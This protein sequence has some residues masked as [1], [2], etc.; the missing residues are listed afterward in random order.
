MEFKPEGILGLG[1]FG[2]VSMGVWRKRDVAIKRPHKDKESIQQYKNERAILS[3]LNHPNIVRYLG[4]LHQS[5]SYG[6]ILELMP[7]GELFKMIRCGEIPRDIQY[8]I[9]LDIAHGLKYLCAERI[10]HR[11]LKSENI[12]LGNHNGRIVAK[13]ADFGFAASLDSGGFG[14]LCG[15]L[16]FIAPELFM[17]YSP[18]P[19]SFNSDTYAFSIIL[20][21]MV[22]RR[23]M[24]ARTASIKEKVIQGER[25]TFKPGSI[26]GDYQQLIIDCWAGNPT[27]RPNISKIIQRLSEIQS[28]LSIS[29]NSSNQSNSS[30]HSEMGE[31][32]DLLV[33]A[34]YTDVFL[35][36]KQLDFY[37]R[38]LFAEHRHVPGE[39]TKKLAENLRAVMVKLVQGDLS[40]EAASEEITM[41]IR[42]GKVTMG[43]HR[44][45]RDII[46]H[47]A[48]CC[49]LLGLP[50]I[51]INKCYSGQLFFNKTVRQQK[52][53]AVTEAVNTAGLLTGPT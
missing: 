24:F 9:A 23:N 16:E 3:H 34:E 8:S 29:L 18:Y 15:T 37:S 4:Q 35:S 1:T 31:C 40:K 45:W 26:S 2:T 33:P 10:V 28:S 46:A 5:Q 51:L 48:S 30:T 43:H 36:I 42:E 13:I 17:A 38:R 20:W 11:D 6:M 27:S 25:G 12:L 50:L 44:R 41:L 14:D 32:A 52:L 39:N 7:K 22:A 47:F 21:M 49:V 19:Y 53:D